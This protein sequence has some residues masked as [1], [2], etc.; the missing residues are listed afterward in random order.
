PGDSGRAP[1]GGQRDARDLEL[2]VDALKNHDGQL[3]KAC[4]QAG[5]SRQRAHRL[6]R[7]HPDRDPRR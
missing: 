4:E 5:I 7:R 6:L 2:L 1:P 3:G